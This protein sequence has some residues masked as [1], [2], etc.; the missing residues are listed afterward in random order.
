MSNRYVSS[1]GADG[2]RVSS[3]A[4]MAQVA[5]VVCALVFVTFLVLTTSHSAFSSATSNANN[6]VSSGSVTIT[7]DDSGTALFNVAAATPGVLGTK[8]ITVTYSGSATPTS[9]VRL[10][11]SAANGGTGLDAYLDLKVEVGTGGSFASC[12]GFTAGSTLFNGTVQGFAAAQTS[13]ATGID[14]TWTPAAAS[15]RTFRFTLTLQDNNAAQSKN[16]TFGYTWE[17]QS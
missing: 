7:D 16:A 4:R 8:C 9:P 1:S 5:A 6:S 13:Y 11:R 15:T 14:T 17:L 10:Y 2:P 12:T 3:P